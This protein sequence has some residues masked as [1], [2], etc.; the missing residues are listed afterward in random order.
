VYGQLRVEYAGSEIEM[1]SRFNNSVQSRPGIDWNHLYNFGE[2]DGI[3]E[4]EWPSWQVG[5]S[6]S[7]TP[8]R[9]FQT[10]SSWPNSVST[11]S[12]IKFVS[13]DPNTSL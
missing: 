4:V 10:V 3:T 12:K 5:C 13:L 1:S 2:L 11:F 6:F 9:T 7:E 8:P